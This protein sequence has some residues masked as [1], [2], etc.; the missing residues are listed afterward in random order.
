MELE[1]CKKCTLP[2]TWE[3]L[4][5]DE[6]GV[7]NM[8]HNWRQKLEV[9]DWEEREKQLI[10]IF[11]G[12]KKR[13]A[14]YDCIVPFSGGKD[15]TFTLWA[16][17]KRYNLK[18][19]VVTFDHC[20]FRPRTL[21]NRTRTFRKLGV[22]VINFTPNW[23]VIKKVML[24]ALKRKGDFCWHCHAGVYA[25]PMQIAVRF[26]VPLVVWGEAGGEYA[27]Y[28]KFEDIEETD[29]W[30]FNRR[31]VLGIRAEDM[32]GFI[33]V[34]LRDLEPFIY[35]SR[36]ELERVGVRSIPLGQFIPWDVKKQVEINKRELAWQEDEIESGYPGP[37]YEKVE[38][39]FTGARDYIKYLKRGFAR[40]TH[41]TTLDIRHGRMSREEAM[42]LIKMHEGK[43][44]KS[45][46]LLL[47][48][49]GITE[50]EF[51]NIALMH[52]IPPARP[53]DPKTLP[54]G[55]KLWDQDLWFREGR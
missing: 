36:E 7:C 33:G 14:R 50:E 40:I 42:K 51:N 15:S 8:C 11:E 6:Q 41:L 3:A 52:V 19:L 27:A 21:E 9:I 13:R 49:L 2:I 30:K 1:R 32:A 44:P 18:P 26:E 48:Y 46:E 22:D 17:V 35:P 24:E 20:F 53:I 45:L 37:T 55:D 54:E 23:H 38:C 34:D 28:F 16:L 12:V 5:F 43:R 47:E 31:I 4:Y 25:Y 10:E 29:E 39:M